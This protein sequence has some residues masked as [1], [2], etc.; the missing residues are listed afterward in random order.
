MTD[1][2]AL[3][4]ATGVVCGAMLFVFFLALVVLTSLALR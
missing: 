1:K 3:W 4:L 2:K